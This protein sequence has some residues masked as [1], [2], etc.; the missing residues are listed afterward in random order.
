MTMNILFPLSIDRQIS[1]PLLRQS[2]YIKE[3]RWK[4][5]LGDGSAAAGTGENE[6]HTCTVPTRPGKVLE[7]PVS[8]QARI[9][10]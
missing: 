7:S 5:L 1:T 6:G 9:G 10:G 8:V 3:N 2:C 4:N